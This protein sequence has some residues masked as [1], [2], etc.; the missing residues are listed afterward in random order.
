MSVTGRLEED[1]G[2]VWYQLDKAQA[3]PGTS[4]NELWVAAEEVDA[5]GACETVGEMAAP[6]VIPGVVAPPTT[7]GDAGGGDSGGA[8]I[9]GGTVPLTGRWTLSLNQTTNASCQG[10]PNVPF[11][12]D[13]VFS[14]VS[15]QVYLTVSG[16]GSSFTDGED[17][18]TRTGPASYFG[19][20]TLD[21]TYNSQLYINV[22]NSR[23]MTGQGT[24]NFFIDGTPCSFTVTFTLT[25]GG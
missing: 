10:G 13:E 23:L 22:V 5:E 3:M 7:G 2:D 20:Y 1:D 6:P 18:F 8:V 17:Q 11:R 24:G 15:W 9:A 4:A 14:E 25:Y 19:N 21:A 12:S 16:D